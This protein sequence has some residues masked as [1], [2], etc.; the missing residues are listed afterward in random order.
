VIFEIARAGEH[1]LQL[2]VDERDVAYLAVDQAGAVRLASLP[3]QPFELRIARITPVAFA[4][5]GNN[6]FEVEATLAQP[7]DSV[8]AG[9]TGVAK[10][11]VGQRSYL[12]LLTHRAWETVARWWWAL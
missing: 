12:W 11:V 3:E 6:F 5:A 2:A 10:V 9:M 4:E 8:S 1:R 7:S